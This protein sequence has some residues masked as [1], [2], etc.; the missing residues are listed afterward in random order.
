MS[1]DR[2]K[3]KERRDAMVIRGA[4]QRNDGYLS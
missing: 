4:H 1:C 3:K 2:G